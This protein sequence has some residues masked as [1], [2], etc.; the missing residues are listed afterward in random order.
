MDWTF[1]A[2]ANKFDVIYVTP[3]DSTFVHKGLG[4][5]NC[6]SFFAAHSLW[7]TARRLGI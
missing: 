4:N 5:I 6:N 7:L 3:T 1:A 2:Q